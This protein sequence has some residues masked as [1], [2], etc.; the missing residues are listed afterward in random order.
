MKSKRYILGVM[1][2]LMCS[3]FMY[4]Y[5]NYQNNKL[6]EEIDALKQEIEA[7]DSEIKKLEAKVKE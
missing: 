3:I 5:L 7:D 2:F 4:S 6:D 1:F